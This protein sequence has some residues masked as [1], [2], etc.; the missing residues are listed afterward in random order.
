MG[1]R[2]LVGATAA[3]LTKP[4]LLLS[5]GALSL[6]ALAL[7]VAACGDDS[8][9]AGPGAGGGGSAGHDAA[10]GQGGIGGTASDAGGDAAGCSRAAIEESMRATLSAHQTDTD[11]SFF[12]ERADGKTFLFERGTSS[13]T[14]VYESASTSKMVA[15]AV[16]LRLVDQGS[17]KLDDTPA[18][19]LAPS[20]WSLAASDP[21][22]APTLAQLLSFTSGLTED[23]L[24]TNLGGFDFETCVGNIV[25][26]NA[27]ST[28]TPG[29]AFHY[30]GAHL[31]VAGAMAVKAAGHAS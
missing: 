9:T 27:N 10:A 20:V 16:I 5:L 7:V 22:Y 1:L 31:Q 8:S 24:C 28:R 4:L 29:A 3:A 25:K 26:A 21:L 13:M 19:Y 12:A 14:T 23:A 18:K 17:M 11:F 30:G 6:G 15:A 2:R